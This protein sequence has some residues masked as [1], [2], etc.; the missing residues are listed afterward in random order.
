MADPNHLPTP[1]VQR[2]YTPLL[3]QLRAAQSITLFQFNLGDN[4]GPLYNLE[5]LDNFDYHLGNFDPIDC[6]LYLISKNWWRICNCG[7]THRQIET[8]SYA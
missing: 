6:H 2:T 8:F 3:F 4:L 7:Q 5:Y 1:P